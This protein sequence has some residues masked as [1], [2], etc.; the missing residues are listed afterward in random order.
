MKI[1]KRHIF[2]FIFAI[3]SCWTGGLIYS[4]FAGK[5]FNWA[6]NAIFGTVF[7]IFIVVRQHKR[8]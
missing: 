5:E 8:R 6:F 2:D 7:S 1:S 4:I 3:L